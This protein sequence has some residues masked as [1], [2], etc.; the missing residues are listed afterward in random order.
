MAETNEKIQVDTTKVTKGTIKYFASP[1]LPTPTI[2]ARVTKALRYFCTSLIIMINS[3][4]IFEA[5]EATVYSFWIGAFILL[6]G[7][8]DIVVGVEPESK[9]GY[10]APND[11]TVN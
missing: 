7:G 3:A 10:S 4:S 1:S 9:Q 5:S 8:V 2:L 6:L 11:P